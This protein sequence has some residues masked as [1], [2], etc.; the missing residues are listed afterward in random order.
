[1]A[2]QSFETTST[3]TA[4]AAAPLTQRPA[5]SHY[6]YYSA[7]VRRRAALVTALKLQAAEIIA[8]LTGGYATRL[9]RG[10]TGP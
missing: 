9:R 7:T 6:Y 3:S 5:A 10:L 8:E 2:R 4:A 1:M